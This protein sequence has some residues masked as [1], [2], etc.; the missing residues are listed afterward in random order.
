MLYTYFTGSAGTRVQVS[1]ALLNATA[2]VNTAN[3]IAGK[4]NE[5]FHA[6]EYIISNFGSSDAFFFCVFAQRRIGKRV[7][8]INF[9]NV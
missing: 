6:D 9:I 2:I 1:Y 5:E 4:P 3:S 8:S 7:G